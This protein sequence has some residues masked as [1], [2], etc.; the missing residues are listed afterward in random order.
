[1]YNLIKSKR[2][3]WGGHVARMGR[4]GMHIGYWLESQIERENWEDQGAGGWTILK[5]I[6]EIGWDSKDWIDLV[7]DGSQWR[8][9]VNRVM[10]LQVL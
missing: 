5:L 6:L 1:M 10:N 8:V 7:Q 9:L 2:M 3:R 4:R